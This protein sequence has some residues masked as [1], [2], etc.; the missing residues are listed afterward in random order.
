MITRDELRYVF[1]KMNSKLPPIYRILKSKFADPS[2]R[3]R[4][5][6]VVI[7]MDSIKIR[8]CKSG[9]RAF[10]SSTYFAKRGKHYVTETH[11]T[12]LDG[13]VV[14]ATESIFMCKVLL[15]GLFQIFVSSMAASS[16]PR[17]VS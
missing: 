15:A 5:N 3:G 6:C 4:K 8:I 10:Q 1:N 16:S 13:E 17:M 11:A 9:N 12:G 2:G 14:S 7:L